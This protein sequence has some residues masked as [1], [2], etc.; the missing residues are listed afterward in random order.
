MVS[1]KVAKDVATEEERKLT[2]A[3]HRNFTHLILT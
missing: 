3:S 1:S 2:N